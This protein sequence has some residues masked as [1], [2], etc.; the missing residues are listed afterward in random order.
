M[1]SPVGMN[2][3]S[4]FILLTGGCELVGLEFNRFDRRVARCFR[5]L[6]IALSRALISSSAGSCLTSSSMVRSST[7]SDVAGSCSVAG[8]LGTMPLAC[9][10]P[11]RDCQL[12]AHIQEV[13][14][15]TI[16]SVLERESSKGCGIQ[17]LYGK[18]SSW[19]RLHFLSIPER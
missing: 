18:H 8:G 15:Q 1:T 12:K 6:R 11:V 2:F 3:S 7:S 4:R 10:R 5:M 14:R 13:R 17:I 9:K 16:V 19:F